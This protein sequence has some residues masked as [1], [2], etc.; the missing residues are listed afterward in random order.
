MRCLAAVAVCILASFAPVLAVVHT[1]AHPSVLHSR[2][3]APPCGHPYRREWAISTFGKKGLA[4][5]GAG[6][7]IQ[8]LQKRPREWGGGASGFGKRLASGFATHVVKNSIQFGVAGARHEDLKYHRSTQ[9]GFER[10]L[11][12]ALVS[13]VVTQKTTTGKRTPAAGRI[14]GAMGSGLISRAWQPA[15]ARSVAGG[16][17]SGGITLGADAAANVAREFWPRHRDRRL[18]ARHGSTR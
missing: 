4:R 8:H 6:A 9:R 3:A 11:Q 1:R 2:P 16:V 12:H 10:R 15:A 14:S 17:A 13:T 18:Q 5:V 7:T